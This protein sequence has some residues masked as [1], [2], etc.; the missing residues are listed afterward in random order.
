MKDWKY[1]VDL[2]PAY[3]PGGLV[4]FTEHRDRVVTILTNS[5]WA[6]DSPNADELME[7]IDELY[8]SWD[9][10]WFDIA[11]SRIYELADEDGCWIWNES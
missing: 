7:R 9:I 6:W 2:E 4:P 8:G 1:G 10:G 5:V 3:D 11:M